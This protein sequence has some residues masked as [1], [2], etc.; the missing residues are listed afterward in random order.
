MQDRNLQNN[1]IMF[2]LIIPNFETLD[3]SKKNRYQSFYCGLCHSLRDNYNQISRLA[4]SY[5]LTF[6]V[7]LLSSLYEPTENKNYCNCIFH[8]GKKYETA[9]NQ[10]SDYTADLTVAFAYHKILDDINDENSLKA[11]VSQRALDNQYK[12]AKAKIPE[13][14]TIIESG[15]NQI[16]E[17]EQ[18]TDKSSG[19]KIA[20]VFGTTLGQ[21]FAPNNDVFKHDLFALGANLGRLIY[22]MDAAIDLENDIKYN[23]YN[24][25]LLI[26]K[27]LDINTIKTEKST[28]KNNIKEQLINLAGIATRYFEKLPL[29][30]DLHLLQNIM[31]EGI[32]LNFNKNYNT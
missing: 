31:Y 20:K 22:F 11:K 17:L 29:E 10:F 13:I 16:S 1:L 8:P 25:Y 27:N 3:Q 12:K 26:Y 28:F 9:Q 15:M 5:D 18:S 7:L 32:W 6:L 21:V 30:Q 4:L 2:G 19:D 14:C 23:N 24:P